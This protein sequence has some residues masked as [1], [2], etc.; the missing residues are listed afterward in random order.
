VGVTQSPPPLSSMNDGQH[1]KPRLLCG[2]EDWVR[3]AKRCGRRFLP[4]LLRGLSKT[5]TW[6]ATVLVE[7]STPAALSAV[8]RLSMIR[9]AVSVDHKSDF[10]KLWGP[11]L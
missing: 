8:G 9:I 7:N 3:F 1:P 11:T 5:Y 6:S 2:R 10:E 4:L